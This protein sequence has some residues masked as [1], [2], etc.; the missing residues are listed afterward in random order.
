[1]ARLKIVKKA[2]DKKAEQM[3]KMPVITPVMTKKITRSDIKKC[4]C[5]I[6]ETLIVGECME[7]RI[8]V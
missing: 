6:F 7:V 3:T 1:M 8:A 2:A 5:G 4:Y